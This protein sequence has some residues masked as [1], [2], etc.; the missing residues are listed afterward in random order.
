MTCLETDIQTKDE[1]REYRRKKNKSQGGKKVKKNAPVE[2]NQNQQ[3]ITKN[4]KQ[5]D[6]QQ[7]AHFLAYRTF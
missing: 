3:H 6:R 4:P 5:K 1:N 7:V 2:T